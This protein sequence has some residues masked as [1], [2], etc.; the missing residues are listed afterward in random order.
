MTIIQKP[1]FLSC[2]RNEETENLDVSLLS[3]VVLDTRQIQN[4]LNNPARWNV[5]GDRRTSFASNYSDPDHL[6]SFPSEY[7]RERFTTQC[8]S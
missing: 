3:V 7:C 2:R 5:W 8:E 1:Q 6:Q 4:Y